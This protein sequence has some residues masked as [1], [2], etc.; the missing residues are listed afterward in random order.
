MNIADNRGKFTAKPHSRHS[1]VMMS[2]RRASEKVRGM[3]LLSKEHRFR[4]PSGKLLFGHSSIVAPPGMPQKHSGWRSVSNF[5][6][7]APNRH[8]FLAV[9]SC[10][11]QY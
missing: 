10:F 9:T 7:D 6:R 4:P 11:R 3:D 2:I 5:D 8:Q 1:A